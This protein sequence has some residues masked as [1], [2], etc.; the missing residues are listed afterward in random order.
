[1][2]LAQL[3]NKCQPGGVQDLDYYIREGA[4]VMGVQLPSGQ[5][6]TAKALLAHIFAEIVHFKTSEFGGAGPMDF[7]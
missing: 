5:Q 3:T 7:A 1:M 4:R 2:K 6:K